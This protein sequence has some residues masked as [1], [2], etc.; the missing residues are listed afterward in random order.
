MSNNRN[1]KSRRV[2]AKK[3]AGKRFTPS[4]IGL[5]AIVGI[6]ALI[7]ILG[8]IGDNL[9]RNYYLK[10]VKIMSGTI[11]QKEFADGKNYIKIRPENAE[12]SVY[13]NED[14]SWIEVNT[15]FFEKHPLNGDIGV[16]LDNLDIYKKKYWGLFGSGQSFEKNLWSINEV[17]DA[18]TDA[19]NANPGK[20]FT[21]QAKI[22]KKKITKRGDHFFVIN[23]DQRSMPVMVDEKVYEKYQV[24]DSISCEFESIGDLTRLVKVNG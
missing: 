22:E 15:A 24:N 6:I 11:A 5:L 21:R 2:A 14:D 7:I 3:T 1:G 18:L 12:S 9:P 4:Q 17:Y 10:D 19:Q 20:N 23:S 16:R 8:V 13:L